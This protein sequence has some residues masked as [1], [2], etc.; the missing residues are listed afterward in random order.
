M[1]FHSKAIEACRNA[2]TQDPHVKRCFEKREESSNWGFLYEYEKNGEKFLMDL[3]FRKTLPLVSLFAHADVR[4][5]RENL[6]TTA[7]Y[8]QLNSSPWEPGM[9][10]VSPTTRHVFYRITVPDAEAPL[11]AATLAW[12]NNCAFDK[13][14][15]C[16]EDLLFLAA[17]EWQGRQAARETK[18]ETTEE[19]AL[20]PE[21]NAQVT[22]ERLKRELRS[23]YRISVSQN[24]DDN[25][26]TLFFSQLERAGELYHEELV[27]DKS[28]CL[29]VAIRPEIRVSEEKRDSLVLFCNEIC[30]SWRVAGPHACSRDGYLW[31]SSPISLWDG[32]VGSPSVS[33]VEAMGMRELFEVL[34]K[35]QDRDEESCFEAGSFSPYREL[36]CRDDD[37]EP[38]RELPDPEWLQR[39]EPGDKP[40]EPPEPEERPDFDPA[41]PFADIFAGS[42]DGGNRTAPS[43]IVYEDEAIPS[44]E[45]LPGSGEGAFWT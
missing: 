28:G 40:A 29:L 10:V 42:M 31:F 4:A 18:P 14:V 34:R 43:G 45:E 17:D 13:L 7:R 15:R 9:L 39:E 44:S 11:S 33:F 12:M 8:C 27:L 26:A 30:S 22:R 1:M 38:V 20:F 24:L 3:R 36:S 16:R 32:P 35:V 23:D 37:D 5:K 21:E 41:D 6:R 25:G 2:L 19:S